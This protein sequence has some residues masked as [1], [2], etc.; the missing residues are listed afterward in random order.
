MLIHRSAS[1]DTQSLAVSGRPGAPLL[2]PADP[3]T[4]RRDGIEIEPVP[5]V[6]PHHHAAQCR[7]AVVPTTTGIRRPRTGL[8]LT[9]I[10]SKPMDSP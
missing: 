1:A 6:T 4:H 7:I 9:R 8:G 10:E 3:L 5:A 2:Q